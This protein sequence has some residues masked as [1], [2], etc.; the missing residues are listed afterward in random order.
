M[1]RSG[2][3]I[4]ACSPPLRRFLD[5][6]SILKK[7]NQFGDIHNLHAV[8]LITHLFRQSSIHTYHAATYQ[9]V[10]YIDIYIYIYISIYNYNPTHPHLHLQLQLHPHPHLHLHLQLHQHLHLQK[11]K[12]IPP[13]KMSPTTTTQ[14]T[15]THSSQPEHQLYT[16]TVPTY[17]IDDSDLTFDGKPL[18]ML[19]E[20][21]RIRAERQGEKK[22]RRGRSRSSK[23]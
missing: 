15:T 6:G 16:N 20:E 5:T 1:R 21:N 10:Q 19:Y 8:V 2:G 7:N 11:T 17:E 13:P 4:S 22:P 9:L 3:Y 18:N 14:T 12:Y 23:K